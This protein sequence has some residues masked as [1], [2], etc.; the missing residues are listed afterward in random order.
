MSEMLGMAKSRVLGA[1]LANHEEAKLLAKL[2]DDQIKELAIEEEQEK[3]RD[4]L[5]KGVGLTVVAIAD[6]PTIFPTI[7]V[8]P[9][10]DMAPFVYLAAG[11][12]LLV[13]IGLALN[14][15]L[16]KPVRARKVGNELVQ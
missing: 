7:Q 10:G 1:D 14:I 11:W 9:A 6:H 5:V 15:N 2:L 3:F 8:P 13:E 4:V 16:D 12:N